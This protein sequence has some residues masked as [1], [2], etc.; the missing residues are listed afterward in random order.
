MEVNVV[1]FVHLY[2]QVRAV[3]SLQREYIHSCAPRGST[4]LSRVWLV[5]VILGIGHHDRELVGVD[6]DFY[7]HVRLHA[8][9]S[10][11]SSFT[12]SV[13]PSWVFCLKD[14]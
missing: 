13:T 2:M 6:D 7:K 8:C 14:V 11:M 3:P 12:R 1:I 10:N 4:L 5:E 9:L